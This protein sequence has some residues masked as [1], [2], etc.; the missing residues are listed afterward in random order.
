[1]SQYSF[2]LTAPP[3][4]DIPRS[5]QRWPGPR[6][7]PQLSPTLPAPR[8]PSGVDRLF[9][10][11]VNFLRCIGLVNGSKECTTRLLQGIGG[12]VVTDS[13]SDVIQ[14]RKAQARFS[15]GQRA[16]GRYKFTVWATRP[17]ATRLERVLNGLRAGGLRGFLGRW[18]L[19]PFLG[20]S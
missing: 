3:A 1:M 17:E 6:K 9:I 10:V 8:A 5:K 18:L 14:Y 11:T 15:A 20:G 16:R 19:R 2:H 13:V 4:P 7:C 12:R